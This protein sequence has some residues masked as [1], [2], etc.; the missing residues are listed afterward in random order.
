MNKIKFEIKALIWLAIPLIIGQFS[1][2]GLNLID[3]VLAGRL[4]A[5]VLAAVAIGS[6][7]WSVGTNI[8]TGLMMALTA[9]TAQLDGAKQRQ[10]VWPLFFQ[11]LWLAAASSAM[12]ALLLFFFSPILFNL[13]GIAETIIA[14]ATLFIRVVVLAA[15]AFAL[16]CA[17]RGISEGL[18]LTRPTAVISLS[19]LTILGPL[20]YILMYGKLGIPA[21]GAL[22][23]AIALVIVWWLQ[24][25]SYFIYVYR[26]SLYSYTGRNKKWHR[27]NWHNISKLLK[28]GLPMSITLL[29]EIGLFVAISLF[30]GGLGET[31]VAAHQ[32]A[33]SV[34]T[35]AFMLPFGLSMAITV[36]VGNAAGRKDMDGVRIA[37]LTGIALAFCIQIISACIMLIFP[38]SIVSFYTRDAQ[39]GVAAITLLYFAGLFQLSD[40]IQV[41]ANGALR[42]LKDTRAPM[43]MTV[44]SYWMV[45]MPIGWVLAFPLK[46]G[47]SGMWIG[48]I[49]G[50]SSAAFTLLTRFL[51]RSRAF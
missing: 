42:G 20:A 35:T 48:L 5:H 27:P 10:L 22:G 6:S 24:A 31:T 12:V 50:L 17:C 18:S 47:A 14:P 30:I 19:G 8:I 16:F 51:Y 34:A 36:R 43:I 11:A 25:I 37:G 1:S 29:M 21:L 49:A 28:I 40:G 46:M 2:V 15:P 23:S 38:N 44:L 13:V 41:A 3:V 26:S 39:V 9:S 33:M 7:V 45:G 32:I 4:N